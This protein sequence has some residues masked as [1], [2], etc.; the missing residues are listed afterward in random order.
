M[1]ETPTGPVLV[2]PYQIVVQVR[3]GMSDLFPAILDTGHNHNFSI[4]E[5][6]LKDWVGQTFPE[7]GALKLGSQRVPLQKADLFLGEKELTIPQGIAVFPDSP[8][9]PLLGLRALAQSQ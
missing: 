1:V 7:I 4:S 3:I 8:R 2:R 6:H 9:L 5:K